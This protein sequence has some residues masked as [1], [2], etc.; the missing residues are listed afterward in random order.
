MNKHSKGNIHLKTFRGATC[1]DMLSYVQPTL[2]RAKSDG[3]IIH[4]GTNDVSAKRKRPSDIADSII[5]V[6]KKCR[7]TGV[8]NVMISSLVQ[9]KSHR[10][11]AKIYEVNDVLRDLCTTDGFVFTENTNLC[12]CDICE[13]L[14]HLSYSG[15]CKLANNFTGAI[16]VFDNAM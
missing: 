13:D 2:D 12:D 9:R 5:S 11:Q 15:T 16:V 7:D 8:R 1:K 10:L 14:L 4:V 6:G 3:I